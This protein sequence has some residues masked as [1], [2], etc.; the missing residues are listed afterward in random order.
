[1]IFLKTES[2]I[3]ILKESGRILSEILKTL[4]K[5]TVVG[6]NILELEEI[7]RKMAKEAGAKPSF[8]GYQPEGASRPYPAAICA[9]LNEVVVHGVPH[10]YIL[11][12]GDVLK[13][14]MGIVFEGMYTDSAVTVAVGKVSPQA[15]KLIASTK[16]ALWEA[17]DVVK[18]GRHIGDIG[19]VIEK[20]A[21]KDN[22]KVLKGLTGHGVGY[23]VHEDPVVF[24]YGRK[25]TGPEIKEG[26]VLAIEPMFS[27]SSEEIVQNDD[28][29][30]SSADGS[31]TAQ[32]EHTVAVTKKGVI[33]L[34]Q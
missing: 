30:Y 1:M 4:E 15:K 20:R 22:F 21:K 10:D 11:R 9:S 17:I 25:G 7:A 24:N 32:F 13:I 29:S 26:M 14:D 3:E 12:S 18:V 23:E 19:Y 16:K 6:T 34:T 33:V 31:L 5:K 2:E 28:E 27:I 8:L